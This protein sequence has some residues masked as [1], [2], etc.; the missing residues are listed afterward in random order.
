MC[1]F[2]C[3]YIYIAKSG[4]KAIKQ[5]L[6]D[7]NVTSLGNITCNRS[8]KSSGDTVAKVDT[9]SKSDAAEAASTGKNTKGEAMKKEL[10][11]PTL[12]EEE[13]IRKKKEELAAFWKAKNDNKAKAREEQKKNVE[14]KKLA[15]KTDQNG[16]S[17]K[18]VR[19]NTTATTTAAPAKYVPT[20][21]SLPS[22]IGTK[23]PVKKQQQ[24]SSSTSSASSSLQSSS[25]QLQV[26]PQPPLPTSS[27]PTS[28]P[29]LSAQ[30]TPLSPKSNSKS[31]QN[32][33]VQKAY[34]CSDPN[35]QRTGTVEKI[36]APPPSV[37][38]A[39]ATAIVKDIFKIEEN[40]RLYVGSD[41]YAEGKKIGE[42]LGPFAK[43]GKCKVGLITMLTEGAQVCIILEE[44]KLK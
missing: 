8:G 1:I 34:L 32:S 17:E 41:V 6:E 12:Q 26:T 25:L 36:S 10:R 24:Q 16:G 3:T 19:E 33:F 29:S 35:N 30:P 22:G 42:L 43:S 7:V 44:Q 20:M 4:E 31:E 14:K 13:D 40:I 18:T 11:P 28:T 2:V 39:V 9:Q 38:A 5:F 15:T 21:L 23:A 37:H 27:V